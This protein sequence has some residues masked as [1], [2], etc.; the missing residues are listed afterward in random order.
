MALSALLPA[1]MGGARRHDRETGVIGR[2]EFTYSCEG[3]DGLMPV[4]PELHSAVV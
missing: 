3:R 1:G 2:R 4:P